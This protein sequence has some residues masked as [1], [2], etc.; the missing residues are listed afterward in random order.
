M[1]ECRDMEYQRYKL[2][3]RELRR[4]EDTKDE[5]TDTEQTSDSQSKP[6]QID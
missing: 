6:E 4:K 5:K 2:L 3:L 1:S